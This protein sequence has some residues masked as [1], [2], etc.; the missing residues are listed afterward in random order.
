MRTFGDKL[1]LA[2]RATRSKRNCVASPPL[3]NQAYA[4]FAS[5]KPIENCAR[6]RVTFWR[7]DRRERPT[8]FIT[9]SSRKANGAV[10]TNTGYLLGRD[11]HRL[12]GPEAPSVMIFYE[13]VGETKFGIEQ[14]AA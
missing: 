10:A 2:I 6:C 3:W 11:L 4:A 7:N 5:P 8:G 13:R 14:L 1:R 12:T 9:N